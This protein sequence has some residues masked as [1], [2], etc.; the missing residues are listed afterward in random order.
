[1]SAWLAMLGRMDEQEGAR[2]AL[3]QSTR[4]GL[5]LSRQNADIN[6][7]TAAA[8]AAGQAG[9]TGLPIDLLEEYAAALRD[10]AA[11]CIQVAEA[12]RVEIQRRG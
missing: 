10:E 5:D 3:I 12:M 8:Y 9:I 6:R 11:S 4:H 1:M 2:R 7:R